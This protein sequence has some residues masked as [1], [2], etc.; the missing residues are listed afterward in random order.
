MLVARELTRQIGS[1]NEETRAATINA[2]LDKV[3]PGERTQ[4]FELVARSLTAIGA[5]DPEKVL[6]ILSVMNRANLVQQSQQNIVPAVWAG[7]VLMGALA[8]TLTA[9]QLPPERQPEMQAAVSSAIDSIE[10]NVR[11]LNQRAEMVKL[12]VDVAIENVGLP[13]HVLD[14]SLKKYDGLLVEAGKQNPGSGGYAG[15]EQP[16]ST[17]HTGGNQLDGQPGRE[18]YVTP[19]HQ[20]NP[21]AVY[22]EG[23]G[24]S[25]AGAK[26]L[27][28]I[29]FDAANG[30]GTIYSP[31]VT[32]KAGEVIFDDF[33]VGTSKGFIGHGSDGAAEL[34]GPLKELLAYTQAKGG[35]TVTLRGYY[36]SEEGAA[37]GA[38][39]VGEKFS[40]SFPATKEGLREF[41]K[42]LEQ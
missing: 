42:G 19:G 14:P 35:E 40:F 28:K 3:A 17:S 32:L 6:G 25:G 1:R 4:D 24:D 10:S 15:G 5:D 7:Y 12:I 21:G 9:T 18:I 39:K 11:D 33:A 26:D 2:L 34:V 37:L 20:L 22:S 30:V 27:G 16:T 29:S 36:A 31:K 8:T 13:I 41:L 38:G 23:A